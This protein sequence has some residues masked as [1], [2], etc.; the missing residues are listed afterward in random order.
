MSLE[1]QSM[2]E[3]ES[4]T[5]TECVLCARCADSCPKSVIALRFTRAT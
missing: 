2:V 3:M 1:V 5:A 4:M